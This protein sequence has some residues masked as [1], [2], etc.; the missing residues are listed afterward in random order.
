LVSKDSKDSIERIA[1]LKSGKQWM[2][3][4]V[5]PCPVFVIIESGIEN[6]IKVGMGDGGR[7]G[8]GGRMGHHMHHCQRKGQSVRSGPG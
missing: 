2:G 4:E 1:G 3:G 8:L 7:L 5:L 6:G